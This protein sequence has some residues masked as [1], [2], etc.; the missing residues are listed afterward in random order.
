[1]TIFKSLNRYDPAQYIGCMEEHI[2]GDY[3]LA[4]DVFEY[5]NYYDFKL[6]KERFIEEE[7]THIVEHAQD[8]LDHKK[9]CINYMDG[10]NCWNG[11]ISCKCGYGI[12]KKRICDGYELTRENK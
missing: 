5:L 3:F 10:R 8:S 4:E 1:M 12:F 2:D 7:Y 11:V 6:S 9:V